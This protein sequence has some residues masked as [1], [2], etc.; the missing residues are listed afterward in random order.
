MSLIDILAVILGKEARTVPKTRIVVPTYLKFPPNI[1]TNLGEVQALQT[2]RLIDIGASAEAKISNGLYRDQLAAAISRFVWSTALAVIG[3][4]R[5]A[6]VDFRLRGAFLAE[7]A[8]VHC[9][10]DPDKCWNFEGVETPGGILVIQAQWG[11]KFKGEFPGYRRGTFASNE[12]GCVIQ[13]GLT[14]VLYEGEALLRECYQDLSG[15]ISE[16]GDVPCLFLNDDEPYLDDESD[17]VAD[18]DYG[19]AS[20][21]KV[22]LGA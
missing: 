9:S 22:P 13:E 11:P 6:V 17:D 20:R 5:V 19:S 3:L 4:N 14:A 15:S 10:I 8:G 7:A 16:N 2:T 1:P 18:L 12:Q 21:G